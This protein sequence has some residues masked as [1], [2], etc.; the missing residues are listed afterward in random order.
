MNVLKVLETSSLFK[1]GT[2]QVLASVYGYAKVRMYLRACSHAHGYIHYHNSDKCEVTFAH[3]SSLVVD[4]LSSCSPTLLC[5]PPLLHSLPLLSSPPLSFNPLCSP[6]LL[7]SPALISGVARDRWSVWGGRVL[8][9]PPRVWDYS[10]VDRSSFSG[11]ER[12][13]CR[14]AWC[15]S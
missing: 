11:Q 7:H 6:P 1:T 14:W 3:C 5:S 2:V 10:A 15:D 9:S 13:G 4:H 12:D 8:S